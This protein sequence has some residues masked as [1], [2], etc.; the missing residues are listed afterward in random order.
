MSDLNS[1]LN[2]FAGDSEVKMLLFLFFVCSYGEYKKKKKKN[3]LFV[4]KNLR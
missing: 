3:T 2:G 4:E 1:L